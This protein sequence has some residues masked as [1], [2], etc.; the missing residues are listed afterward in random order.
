[1]TPDEQDYL[2]SK[3]RSIAEAAACWALMIGASIVGFAWESLGWWGVLL[4][5]AAAAVAAGLG[6]LAEVTK[7]ADNASYETDPRDY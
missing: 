5:A 3:E 7:A 4:I 1:M 2:E 6:A